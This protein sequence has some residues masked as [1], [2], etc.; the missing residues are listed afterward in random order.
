M[1]Y[2]VSAHCTDCIERPIETWTTQTLLSFYFYDDWL[3]VPR[4][5]VE[6]ELYGRPMP[7]PQQCGIQAASVTYTTAH[8]NAESLTH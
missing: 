8:G 4:L 1:Q 5:G 2:T 3:E 6:S 7:K